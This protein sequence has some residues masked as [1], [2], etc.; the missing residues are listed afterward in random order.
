MIERFCE[1]CEK[2][3]KDE[4][5]IFSSEWNKRFETINIAPYS[6]SPKR[7]PLDLEKNH[8]EIRYELALLAARMK[9]VSFEEENEVRYIEIVGIE[10]HSRLIYRN[11]N[12]LIIPYKLMQINDSSIELIT[13]GSSLDQEL[14][15]HSLNSIKSNYHLKFSIEK[16][17]IPYRG[18]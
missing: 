12:S 13:L 2:L 14:N 8:T 17:P 9:D 18:W 3:V 7:N 4:R 15:I 16:S 10:D 11:K 5:I 6:E 1:N